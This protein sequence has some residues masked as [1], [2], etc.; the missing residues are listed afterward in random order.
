MLKVR[1][2][3]RFPGDRSTSLTAECVLTRLLLMAGCW[4]TLLQETVSQC[5]DTS[6]IFCVNKFKELYCHYAMLPR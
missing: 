4:I 2:K 3:S 1:D 6:L 5:C